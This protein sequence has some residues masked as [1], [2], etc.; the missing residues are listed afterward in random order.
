MASDLPPKK[1]RLGEPPNEKPLKLDMGFEDAVERFMRSP[2]MPKDA[3]KPK[4]RQAREK[5][6][7]K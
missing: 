1:K 3:T 5:G 7:R 6:R 2:P 4:E